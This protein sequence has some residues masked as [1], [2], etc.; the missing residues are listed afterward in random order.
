MPSKALFEQFGSGSVNDNILTTYP[1]LSTNAEASDRA[2]QEAPKHGG[3]HA[4]PSF[5]QTRLV[6]AA[7]TVLGFHWIAL[8]ARDQ[9]LRTS[10]WV[11]MPPSKPALPS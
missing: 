8:P 11:R 1:A 3:D 6:D 5:V 4:S 9:R 10:R 7:G 2:Q